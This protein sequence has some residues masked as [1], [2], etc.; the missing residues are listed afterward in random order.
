MM[1]NTFLKTPVEPH[2]FALAS[3]LHPRV[4]AIPECH[5]GWLNGDIMRRIVIFVMEE[6]LKW[7]FP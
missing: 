5:L 7:G 1:R 3:A 4:A 6:D 2:L